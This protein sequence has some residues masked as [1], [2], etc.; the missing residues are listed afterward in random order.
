MNQHV[1]KISFL[2]LACCILAFSCLPAKGIESNS[3][4]SIVETK[5][6]KLQ[7]AME[8]GICVWRGIPYSKPPVGDLRFRAPM[9]PDSWTGI[10]NA[11]VF[12]PV[13]PQIK[14]TVKEKEL[15]SEDCLYLNVWSP[16]ADGKKRPVMFWIHGGGFVSG[17][18]SLPM[19]D[20]AELAKKGDVVVVTINYRLGP[21]GFLY[22]KDIKGGKDFESNLGI[23]DQVAALKWVKENIAA[24]GGD[25]ETVTIFGESAGGISVETLMCTPSAKGLFKRAIAE[26][27]PPEALWTPQVATSITKRYLK[28]VGVPED[29]L[30]MLKRLP[31]DT[32]ESALKKLMKA[33]IKET[34]LL[35]V[36][37]PTIDGDFIPHDLLSTI[38]AGQCSGVDLLIGTNKNEANLFALKKLNM[39]PVTAEQLAPYVAHIPADKRQLLFSTYPDYPSRDGILDLIT[40]GI[41]RIPCI[42]LAGLQCEHASTYMYRFDWCS[43]PLRTIGLKACHG[44]ELPFVFGTFHTSLAKKVLLFAN[45]RRI[46]SLSNQIQTAWLNF[47]RTGDPN[48][49]GM[50]N[51]KKYN[52]ADR[53]T[54][55]FD[56]KNRFVNDP[57]VEQRKA[58]KGVN[59]FQ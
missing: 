8:Q 4:G 40:D 12:G 28:I 50:E 35:K 42:Q 26:S 16:A 33:F 56:K 34:D 36:F 41:F 6:G 13:A 58:W 52:D 3:S 48:S 47:A 10:K 19:Y 20:G 21:L 49:A 32:L 2:P 46:H 44:L 24:F 30:F 51:W 37:C 25:P 45:K 14:R 23:R 57:D 55:I 1:L 39:A 54:M 43:K 38:K 17:S 5:Q 29:S 27:G 31:A 15:Q 59:L 11:T 9:P 53:S 18:G 7:G 22:F